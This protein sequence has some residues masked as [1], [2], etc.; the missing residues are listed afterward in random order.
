MFVSAIIS[1]SRHCSR[2][3]PDSR[4]AITTNSQLVCGMPFSMNNCSVV[5]GS[6]TT[7]RATVAS[8]ESWTLRPITSMAEARS[9][10][11][12][13]ASAPA[14]LGSMTENCRTGAPWSMSVSASMMGKMRRAPWLSAFE[15]VFN[16]QS[17]RRPVMDICADRCWRCWGMC[18]S[19]GPWKIRCVIRVPS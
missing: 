9:N 14:R 2:P 10:F 12:K 5:S 3:G 6:E 15:S 17:T 13:A 19:H 8:R 11:T 16:A 4:M 7:R 18:V 1:V